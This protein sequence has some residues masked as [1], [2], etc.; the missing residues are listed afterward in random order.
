MDVEEH[1]K[2]KNK[3]KTRIPDFQPKLP[4]PA[5]VKKDQHEELFEK[6]LE[7][8][9][10]LQI[11]VPFVKVLAQIPR[12]AKFLKELLNNKRKLEEVATITLSENA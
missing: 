5:K 10:T 3:D 7:M 2:G 4:Y 6:F 11:N 1:E 12:Y 9:K 8:F